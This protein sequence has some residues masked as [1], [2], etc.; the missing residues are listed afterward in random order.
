[1]FYA[2]WHN[3][4]NNKI[5]FTLLE[6]NLDKYITLKR[7]SKW[8]SKKK[9][10]INDISIKEIDK[11]NNPLIIAVQHNHLKMVQ[12]L[13]DECHINVNYARDTVTPLHLAA[14]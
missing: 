1:M 9:V 8:I 7:Q 2:I 6:E 3:N 14:Q 5:T 12:F 13:I 11:G 10:D 4:L